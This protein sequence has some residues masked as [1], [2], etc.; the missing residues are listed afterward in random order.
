M[1]NEEI[2]KNDKFDQRSFQH[3][4]ELNSETIVDTRLR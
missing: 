1:G 2:K 3:G 4:S